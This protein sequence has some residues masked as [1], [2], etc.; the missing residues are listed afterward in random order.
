M[1][2]ILIVDD[3]IRQVKALSA[4]IRRLR[5]AYRTLEAT[6]TAA[7]WELLENEAVDAVLTDIRMPDEDGLTLVE[8][9]SSR[10]PHIK[11]V[12]ISGYG[13]F[14][15]AQKAIEHRVVEYIVKPIGLADIERI[16]AKLEDLHAE[17]TKQSQLS[18]ERFWQD[19]LFGNGPYRQQPL[20]ERYAPPDGP[21]LVIVFEPGRTDADCSLSLIRNRWAAEAASLGHSVTVADPASGRTAAIVWLNLALAAKPS[22]SVMKISRLLE[23]VKSD[24]GEQITVGV[25][26]MRPALHETLT[27][28]YAEALLALKHRFYTPEETVYW[29]SDTLPFTERAA[30]S[31]KEMA[32]PMLTAI[33]AG[34]STRAIELVNA[35]FQRKEAPPYPDPALIRDE[36]DMLLWQLLHGMQNVLPADSQEWTFARIR[37]RFQEYGD[38]RELRLRFK[39]LVLQLLELSEKTQVDKN[40]LII[41]RCHHYLQQHFMEELSLESVAA[42]YHFNASYFSHLFK[43]RTGMNFSEYILELRIN[44]AKRL[45]AESDV[46]IAEISEQCGFRTP[47]YF[48]KMF[49]R[50]VGLSPNTF[51]HMHHKGVAER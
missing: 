45:L 29:G 51:R 50:E 27:E 5:P 8:R 23:K 34:E 25:S 49:K 3:E 18:K 48:N 16:V 36:V 22:D 12:L 15:Y 10:K 28:A 1:I 24:G 6:N 26:R 14:D 46:K 44:K 38:Y 42:R 33:K 30:P 32:D 4:I 19:A 41:L 11:S 31:A 13:Q 47:A 17:D 40:G 21:G 2:T 39:E 7:A 43:L 35:F 20:F 37:K 9:I